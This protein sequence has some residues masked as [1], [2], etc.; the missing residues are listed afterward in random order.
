M[1]RLTHG[2][3]LKSSLKLFAATVR[4]KHLCGPL[5]ECPALRLRRQYLAY[6]YLLCKASKL[7]L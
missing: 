7:Q 4:E 1:C 5:F 6:S 3:N 2:T